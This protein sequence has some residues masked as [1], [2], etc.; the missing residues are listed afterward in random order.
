[1]NAA[2]RCW[3]I[4][5]VSIRY[6][7][8][9]MKSVNSARSRTEKPLSCPVVSMPHAPSPTATGWVPPPARTAFTSSDAHAS[10]MGRGASPP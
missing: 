3:R 6:T 2:F 9:P 5:S 1:M 7:C 8:G 4:W 10:T